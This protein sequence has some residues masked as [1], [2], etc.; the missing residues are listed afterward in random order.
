MKT[1]FFYGL[2]MEP[3]MLREKG[4]SPHNVDKAY[5]DGFEL[6]IGQRATLVAD[7]QSCAFGTI[8]SLQES[9]LRELYS[10]EVVEDY[11]PQVVH[12]KTMDGEPVEAIAYL[13]P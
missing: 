5:V 1:V 11:L 7:N 6:K 8:M 10:G 13:L 2:F 12:V 4:L 3:D 9:E